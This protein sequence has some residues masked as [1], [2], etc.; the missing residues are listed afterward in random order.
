MPAAPYPLGGEPRDVVDDVR[1]LGGFGIVAHPDSPKPELRWRDWTRAVRRR[2]K[3][4]TSTRS[5][6]VRA[7]ADRMARAAARSA[8]RCSTIRS[9]PPRRSRG[10]VQPGTERS[11]ALGRA[12]A[13]AGASSRWPAPTRTRSSRSARRRSR[14]QPVR[15]CRSRATN[16]RSAS[17]SVHV[18]PDRPFTG[19]AAADA[20]VAAARRFAP[21][22]STRRV[23][24]VADAAVVRVHRHQRARHRARR[25]RARRRRPR[26]AARA[27]QRAGRVHHDR[28][29]GRR[30]ELARRQAQDFD[31]DAPAGPASTGWRSVPTGRPPSSPGSRAIPIYVR[32]PET[33]ATP[34]AGA[35][36]RRRE[37][38]L[39]RDGRRGWRVE[40]DP[41]SLGAR[42]R[43]AARRRRRELRLRFGLAG[44]P[45]AGQCGRA[46]R[47]HADGR[48]A[49]T[50]V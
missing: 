50:I 15:R 11:D 29:D 4:S 48:R 49:R 10:L 5:W 32:A 26:H 24:G 25:R 45:P 34:R 9:D 37:P 13:G 28:L 31:V 17:L 42:R 46:G 43:R 21:A 12:G 36:R 35:A 41:T 38:T 2:S 7:A 18:R 3:C 6:R 33:P 40:H 19:D 47:R 39:R 16:R 23:D 1:R 27:Q 14:R 8:R 30:V 20:A 22:I 44:G